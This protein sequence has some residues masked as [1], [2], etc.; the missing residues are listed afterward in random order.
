M[1]TRTRRAAAPL[2]KVMGVVL[3][4]AIAACGGS[5]AAPVDTGPVTQ[6]IGSENIVMA[7]SDNIVGGPLL[8]GALVPSRE[9]R[10]RAEVAG[11]VLSTSIEAGQRV[12]VG[13]VL[14][15]IDDASL[16]D[17][18]LSARSGLTT[19]E[20]T[21]TQAERELERARTLAK[22]GAIAVRDVE[23]AER[24]ALQ[25]KAGLDDAKARVAARAKALGNTVLRA[26]FAGVVSERS[27]NAG[28]IVT[29][30]AAMFT[31]VDPS[32]LRLEGSV[33]A[34]AAGRVAVGAKVDFALNGYPDRVF[35]G[36]VSQV[37]PV[38]DPVT[39]QVRII[40]T[41]PNLTGT[42]VGGLFAE[43]RV[44]TETHEGVVVPESAIDQR[45]VNPFAVRLRNGQVERVDVT[46]GVRDAA[47]ER[48]EILSGVSLGDTL[49]LGAARAISVGTSVKVNEPS[50]ATRAPAS[51]A[52][53]TAVT[54][55]PAD[56]STR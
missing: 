6:Q 10:I 44:A 30:G 28:D 8:T 56:S 22:A 23:S 31:I 49:L 27:V 16:A 54:P 32:S 18:A 19:A 20:L 21:Y 53:P 15:R 45:G 3:L 55:A 13:T 38:A 11:R 41:L 37:N 34:E 51:P 26:P 35:A 24:A 50:D 5:D 14:A 36:R 4:G 40:A 48:L 47:N 43:G 9:A 42:L 17:D 33:P 1:S 46:L 7:T 12:S 25:A 2:K 52:A 39:R 29:P